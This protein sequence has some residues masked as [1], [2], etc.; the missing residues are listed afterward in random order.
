ML[1]AKAGAII[2][3][4]CSCYITD[5][6]GRKAG[7]V[8]CSMLSIL[9]AAGLTGSPNIGAFIT[10]RFFAGA[11]SWGY[12]AVGMPQL[13]FELKTSNAVEQPRSTAPSWHPRLSGA[14]SSA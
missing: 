4:L 9:G 11:G 8:Y 1:T 2:G 10:F 6:Y 5:T 12:T 7:M 14:F 13:I 3:C